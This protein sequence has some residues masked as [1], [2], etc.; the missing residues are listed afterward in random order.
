MRGASDQIGQ[1]LRR[2]REQRG[3]SLRALATGVGLT[4]SLLSQIENGQANP[5]V[6]TLFMLAETLGIPVAYFFDG[7]DAEGAAHRAANPVVQASDRQRIDLGQGVTW[8]SLLTA[9]EAG[10][11]FMVIRYAPGAVSAPTLQRHSGRDY[12]LVLRG[13]LTVRLVFAEHVLGPGASISFDATLP[14]QLA[15]LGDTP[16]E[17]VWLRLDVTAR[18]SV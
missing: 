10:L 7:G 9:P 6:D 16:M 17:A 5:S 14:H 12:G 8:E 4:A 13:H 11:E 3:L 1:R 2:A 18:N 15:N